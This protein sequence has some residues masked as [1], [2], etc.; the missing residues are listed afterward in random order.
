MGSLIRRN[1]ALVFAVD[2]KTRT[3]FE[4][5][6]L[7][8]ESTPE[9]N[10]GPLRISAVDAEALTVRL[11]ADIYAGAPTRHVVTA[12]A[13]FYVLA[14]QSGTFRR[15]L[16]HADYICADGMPIVRMCRLL[17]AEQVERI[18][19]VDLIPPLC[20]AA[21]ANNLPIY[22]LGGLPGAAGATAALLMDRFPGL[23]VSGVGC[24]PVG[25]EERPEVL[26]EVLRSIRAARPAILFVALGAPKQ[27]YFIQRHIRQLG[28]PVA[29]G[30]GGSFELLAGIRRRAPLWM[31]RA[32][33]EW[34]FRWMQ[35]PRRLAYRYLVG[36]PL[37]TCYALRFLLSEDAAEAKREYLE[38]SHDTAA[39]T[40]A[41]DGQRA[42]S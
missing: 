14:N 36:N 6:P 7:A 39:L 8:Q 9:V 4:A 2:E 25:F 16:E 31:Q 13:Q 34:V 22:L 40:S 24:P 29:V 30:V 32:G 15:C 20:A 12:N 26:N 3:P 19:G 21:A 18:T 23:E 28:V 33:L 27:E 42:A 10:V 5:P 41:P 35:E 11:I 37:F 1:R 38:Q 17:G